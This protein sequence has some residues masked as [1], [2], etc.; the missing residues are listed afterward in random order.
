MAT[1]RSVF[2]TSRV[3]SFASRC[4]GNPNPS[5]PR[6]QVG[7]GRLCELAVWALGSLHLFCVAVP[8][9]LLV[10]RLTGTA[11]CNLYNPGHVQPREVVGDSYLALDTYCHVLAFSRTRAARCGI[12][13][14]STH[15]REGCLGM[16]QIAPPG[17]YAWYKGQIFGA[18]LPLSF[19]PT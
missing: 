11:V 19:A 13:P 18:A 6:S 8:Q 10:T 16:D 5:M 14:V 15:L 12:P 3:Y 1:K 2:R 4:V 9:C 17:Q 7:L